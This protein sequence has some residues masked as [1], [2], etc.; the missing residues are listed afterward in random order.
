MKT[1]KQ[2][3]K[4]AARLRRTI[5]ASEARLAVLRTYTAEN[6]DQGKYGQ[7]GLPAIGPCKEIADDTELG[8]EYLRYRKEGLNGSVRPSDAIILHRCDNRRCVEE[9]HLFWGTVSDN[10]RDCLLK[11]RHPRWKRE[12]GFHTVLEDIAILEVRIAKQR[13]LLLTAESCLALGVY[14]S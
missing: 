3:R 14:K 8:R 5:R 6:Y 11:R 7:L 9:S 1:E 2:Y 4:Q 13:H 12:P 10:A